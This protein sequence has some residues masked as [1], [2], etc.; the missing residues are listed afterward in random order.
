MPAISADTVVLPRA[1][2]PGP[3]A[4]VRSVRLARSIC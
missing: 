2:E 3:D 4:T 1:A